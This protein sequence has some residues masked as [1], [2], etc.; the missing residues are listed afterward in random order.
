MSLRSCGL[1]GWT[2]ASGQ[3]ESH[4]GPVEVIRLGP[5]DL[6]RGELADAQRAAT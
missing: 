3:L 6:H 4:R 5:L 1:R 2:A